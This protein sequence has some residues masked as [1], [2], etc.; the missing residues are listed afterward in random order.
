MARALRLCAWQLHEH[1]QH[2]HVADAVHP[3]TASLGFNE[4]V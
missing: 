3:D 2:R 1:Q 4:G